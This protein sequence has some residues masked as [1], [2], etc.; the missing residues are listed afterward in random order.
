MLQNDA[1]VLGLLLVI[2]AMVFYTASLPKKGWQKFYS[3]FPPLLLCYFIPGLLNSFGVI[4][5]ADSQLY[6]VVSRYLLPACLVLFTLGMDWKQLAKLGPSAVI[7]ML[8]G[9]CSIIIGGPV[10]LFLVGKISPETVAGEGPDAIWRGLATIAGSWIGGGA[11]QTALREVFKPSDRLFSQIVA[12]D[13]ITAELWMAVLIYGAGFATKIDHFL[14]ADSSQIDEVKNHLEE[15]QQTN[16]RIPATR[17]YIYLCAVG[18][19]ATGLAHWLAEKITPYLATNYPALEKYSLTS[20]FFW[21]T[22]LVT[23]M[24]I[25]FS[26][27][28]LRKLENAGAS[29]LGSVFL[30]ILV[31]TIGMQMDLGSIADNPGLFAI[32]AIWMLVHAGTIVAV[33]RWLK[34]PYFFLAVSSQA[35]VGGSASASV[36]AAAFHPSLAS[37]GILLAILGYAIG[38]YGGYLSALMMQWVSE[39]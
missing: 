38:T 19:G 39:M 35:N 34:I 23:L 36:V 21:I 25:I 27:T 5:G 2:L 1:S 32:G 17:D 15:F 29:K 30:Y 31:A 12:V 18:L 22:G 37:V 4:K 8:V 11:N 26:L 10:A 20:N 28:P 9:S 14:K 7:L 16:Q 33:A 24:G 6:P 3:V 13:V